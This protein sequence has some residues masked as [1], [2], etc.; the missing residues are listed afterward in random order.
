MVG[1]WPVR[2]ITVENKQDLGTVGELYRIKTFL[3]IKRDIVYETAFS[4]LLSWGIDNVNDV[5]R[6]LKS[7]AL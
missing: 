7:M 4:T 5:V 2:D 6:K 1:E 3:L